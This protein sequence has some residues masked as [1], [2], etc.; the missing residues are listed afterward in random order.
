M[1]S[2]E[3]PIYEMRNVSTNV[4]WKDI[5]APSEDLSVPHFPWIGECSDLR[6]RVEFLVDVHDKGLSEW[7]NALVAQFLGKIPNFAAFQKAINLMWGD[8]IDLRPAGRNLFII[9]FSDAA[10]RD[11]I[12]EKGPWQIKGQSLIVRKW[13]A[14][15]EN[16]E[17]YLKKLPVWVELKGI[18]L[19][20]F[21]RRGIGYISSVL[22]VP[23][24]MDR[25]TAEKKRLEYA[26]V[27]I[28]IDVEKEV[29]RFIEVVRKNG[30]LA[31][32]EVVIPWM[33]VKCAECKVFGHSSKFVPKSKLIQSM[34]ISLVSLLK[35][36]G[37]N[38]RL[39]RVKVLIVW[40]FLILFL[41]QGKRSL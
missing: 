8:D 15:M 35:F 21:T 38:L 9:Q 17:M 14:D 2:G 23:L 26:R 3:I 29:P 24:Y 41:L 40:L 5:L 19:E 31:E 6:P 34:F 1:A 16:L 37:K 39:R 7:E 13:A 4:S 33:P 11:R 32:V 36:G 18:P 20:L 28:E 25:F 12:L 22:G 30:G 27:C 10:T